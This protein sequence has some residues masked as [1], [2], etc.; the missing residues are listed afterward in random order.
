MAQTG[1]SR[2]SHSILSDDPWVTGRDAQQ[3]E[4]WTIRCDPALFPVAKRMNADAEPL[5]KLFLGEA[6]K[7]P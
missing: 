6:N 7:A 2:S 4:A 1:G 3:R 5:G